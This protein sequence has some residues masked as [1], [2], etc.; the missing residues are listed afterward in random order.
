M[1]GIIFLAI[2]S[3]GLAAFMVNRLY[4]L[5]TKHQIN[6]KGFIY[7]RADKPIYYWFW[8]G[9]ATFGLCAG[10]ILFVLSIAVLRGWTP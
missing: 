5:F 7:S 9:A 10:L 3:A 2:T 4:V 1:L 8:V 6:V